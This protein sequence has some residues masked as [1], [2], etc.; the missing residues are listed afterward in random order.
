MSN[1][2]LLEKLEVLQNVLIGSVTGGASNSQQYREIREELFGIPG[3]KESLPSFIR[4]CTDLNQFWHLIKREGNMPSYASRRE[5]VWKAFKPLVESLESG[6]KVDAQA[7]FPKGATHDAYTHIRAIL[8]EARKSIFIIDGYMDSSIYTVLSTI[9]G[10]LDI[11]FLS[12][13]VPNDFALEAKRFVQQHTTFT[14]TIRTV[15]D[16]HD[17]FIVIDG[18]SCY[19][20]GASIKDAGNRAFTIV[21]LRDLPVVEFF[22]RYAQDVWNSA[23]VVL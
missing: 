12:S 2:E 9:T 16:F 20:L 8:Q 15:R 21:P 13:K 17:R 3:M 10:S 5:F 6:Q 4:T 11:R 22:Q 19:L 18:N 7:F 23:A 1:Q 14:L